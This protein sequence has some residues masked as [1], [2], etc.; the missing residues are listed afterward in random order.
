MRHDNAILAAG[1][2]PAGTIRVGTAGVGGSA[3]GSRHWR[4][5]AL[6]ILALPQVLLAGVALVQPTP[7]AAQA[8]APVNPGQELGVALGRLARNPQDIEALLVAGQAALVMNDPDAA[9]GFFS[10]ADRISPH[11]PRVLL[12]LASARVRAEQPLVALPLF[13]AAEKLAPL[14]GYALTDRGLA[15]DLLGDNA[16]AQRDYRKA[17]SMGPRPEASRR[18]AISL[19]IVGDRRGVE[20][21]LAP[22]LQQQDHAAWRARAFAFAILGREDEAVAIA[23][24]TMPAQLA[25]AMT[26]YLRYMR[27]LTP[28]QQAA[29]ANLG[30]FPRAAEIGQ[31]DPAIARYAQEHRLTRASAAES[32]LDPAGK[33]LGAGAEAKDESPRKHR[34][35]EKA[36]REALVGTGADTGAGTGSEAGSDEA[37]AAV[38]PPDPM[39]SREQAQPVPVELARAPLRTPPPYQAPAPTR[40]EATAKTEPGFTALASA[41]S[42]AKPDAN[43]DLSRL[44][45]TSGP[46]VP[47]VKEVPPQVVPPPPPASS[48][49]AALA[50]AQPAPAPGNTAVG[51]LPPPPAAAPMSTPASVLTP[52]ST[53]ASAFPVATASATPSPAP[54]PTV[55]LPLAGTGKGPSH[56]PSFSEAFLDLGAK[57]DASP[58]APRKPEAAKSAPDQSEKPPCEKGSSG[59]KAKACAKGGKPTIAKA[60]PPPS[61]PSRI[62]VQVGVG[63]D[64]DRLLH[65]WRRW[66][67]DD[68]ALFRGRKPFVSEWGRATRLLTGPFESEDMARAFVDKLK[69]ADHNDAFT[70]LSPAGQTVDPLDTK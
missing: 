6:A 15:H 55:S 45:A 64:T 54:A 50:S 63:R 24:S 67:K 29:A 39:P 13:E 68:P 25:E 42:G 53:P 11:N 35:H 10:R 62:W 46:Q 19:A 49:P 48:P 40:A 51:E 59:D 47:T 36:P 9:A 41:P 4:A 60:P 70:W 16:A 66:A 22:L 56:R 5:R 27:K 8:P 44:P 17:L 33:P 1:P 20:E 69:K 30:H 12:G 26:P 7:A 14:D 32:R 23:R 58:P 31:D 21:T 34:K 2:M 18:L 52:V 38:A 57:Q 37:T 61:H 65:D 3:P 43:F 28:A